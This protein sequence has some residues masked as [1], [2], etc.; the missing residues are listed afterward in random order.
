MQVNSMA[1]KTA[2]YGLLQTVPYKYMI[3][4]AVHWIYNFIKMKTAERNEWGNMKS[5]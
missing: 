4:F 2:D 1:N 3:D 5:C